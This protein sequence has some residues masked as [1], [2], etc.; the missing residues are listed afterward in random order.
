MARNATTFVVTGVCCAM[1]EAVLRKRLDAGLGPARYSY[2][3]VTCE[4][5][6]PRNVPPAEVMAGV[7]QAGFGIR[8][9]HARTSPDPFLRRHR[10]AL[11]TAAAAVVALAGTGFLE[12]GGTV[13][14][15]VLLALAILV[16]GWEVFRKALHTVRQRMLDM[17]VLM[18]VAVIG[19]LGIGR[20]EEGAAVIVLFSVSLML[21][22]YS[23][24]RTR[25]AVASLMQLS[26]EEAVLIT[27]EGERTVAASTVQPGQRIM[28]RPGMRIPLDGIVREGN[29]SVSEALLTG[30][31]APV[32]K[33]PGMEVYAGCMNGRGALAV[34]VSRRFEETRLAHIVH[35]VE[36]AQHQRAPMQTFTE[37]FARVYT[38]IV[39]AGALA[40]AAV[41][42]L[43]LGGPPIVWLYRALVMLVIA[44]PCALVIST[45]V[46]IVSALT[47]AARAGILI[48]G[49]KHLETLAR[50]RAIAFDKT[51][52]LTEGRLRVTDLIPLNSMPPGRLLRIFAALEQ[53]SEHPLAS[54]VVSEADAAGVDYRTVTIERF[55]ALPGQ[56]VRAVV[57]GDVYFLG[58]RVLA[59]MHG[60]GS[61]AA[62]AATG[63]L[64]EEGKAAL[65]LGREGEAL[66]ALGLKDS[67]R[68]SGAGLVRELHATG[69]GHLVM[70]SGDSASAVDRLGAELGLDHGRGSLLPADKVAAVQA[71]RRS[72]GEVAMVG[73]G[74]N[75]TPALAA[76]SVGIAM[77]ASGADAALE[78]AD[79]VLMADNL[80]LLPP[81]IRHSR[82]AVDIIRQN[83]AFAL[84]LKLA[85]LLLSVAGLA[86]LWMALLAD[87][88]A[89]LL[90]ILNGM[91]ALRPLRPPH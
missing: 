69:I 18:T 24:A 60:F 22:S 73:D 47:S 37:R 63:R 91:R 2:N 77:G 35:L 39:L 66:G 49:G 20:W 8:E 72:Y 85:F 51:G 44:C 1:E 84:L 54:A 56:G 57:D 3:P 58:N 21:E 32:E 36:E 71:L 55:E 13:A 90:V 9:R 50:V 75:D 61:A 70:L 59:E 88:G 86:T 6:V 64:E 29:S 79:V 31:A 17:N 48:K 7:R 62:V 16:G 28:I 89:A 40:I 67:A 46:T 81:L 76:S 78:S 80:E 53:R 25:R 83:I 15:R 19:A 14:G 5:R 11:G 26:P 38:W 34:E 68:H 10:Q 82:N 74:L 52:T 27:G 65:L 33:R 4:L 30:E 43:L 45:P 42:P 87:D 41:P 12:T 23:T